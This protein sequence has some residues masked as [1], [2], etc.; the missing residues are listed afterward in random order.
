[1]IWTVGWNQDNDRIEYYSQVDVMSWLL[2]NV[3][4]GITK[5]LLKHHSPLHSTT[6]FVSTLV[7]RVGS[8]DHL[9]NYQGLS[10]SMIFPLV[11]YITTNIEREETEFWQVKLR[12][13]LH[14]LSSFSCPAKVHEPVGFLA[15]GFT[16]GSM[17]I[18]W[19]SLR[20]S[21]CSSSLICQLAWPMMNGFPWQTSLSL[22]FDVDHVNV[23]PSLHQLNS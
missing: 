22:G 1:M 7:S 17:R 19:F 9:T 3:Q 11:K 20:P 14:W 13:H 12:C 21:S 16:T 8:V 4:R 10:T 18:L 23:R 2:C 6:H 5:S 15:G